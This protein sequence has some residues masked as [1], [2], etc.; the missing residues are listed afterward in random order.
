MFYILFTLMP[1]NT[2][3]LLKFNQ[4][5]SLYQASSIILV[6]S[7][8][9]TVGGNLSTLSKPMQ[10]QGHKNSTQKGPGSPHREFEP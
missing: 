1:G 9:P 5:M 4:Y 7:I 10:A 3:S 6:F 2:H 8:N